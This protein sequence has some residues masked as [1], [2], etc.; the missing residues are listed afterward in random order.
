MENVWKKVVKKSRSTANS[1]MSFFDI[2]A[3]PVLKL[4]FILF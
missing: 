3:E 4:D 1:M 2:S